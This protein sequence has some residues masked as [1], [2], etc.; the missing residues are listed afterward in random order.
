MTELINVTENEE[1]SALVE[2]I[3]DKAKDRAFQPEKLA[4]ELREFLYTRIRHYANVLGYHPYEILR[5]NCAGKSPRLITIGMPVF[6]C[7]TE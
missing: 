3:I 2:S 5:L 6:R 4:K 7:L 1:F